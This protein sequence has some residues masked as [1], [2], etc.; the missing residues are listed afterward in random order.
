M[1]LFICYQQKIKKRSGA[2][3]VRGEGS[4]RSR[5]PPPWNFQKYTSQTTT[6]Q[7]LRHNEGFFLFMHLKFSPARF[8][9]LLLYLNIPQQK[10]ESAFMFGHYFS[11]RFCRNFLGRTSFL[12][13]PHLCITAKPLCISQYTPSL[14]KMSNYKSMY[15]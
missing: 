2:D 7:G 9:H 1:N 11:N 3:L 6:F 4:E 15:K 13:F 14:V 10:N 5:P 12:Y 8:A